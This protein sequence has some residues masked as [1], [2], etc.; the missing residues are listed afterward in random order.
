MVTGLD[1]LVSVWGTPT[2]M[3]TDASCTAA[4]W[5]EGLGFV[6]IYGSL[7]AKTYRVDKIFNNKK[8]KRLRSAQLV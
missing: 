6:L 8:L 7:C 2:G 1:V 4:L 3:F 5:L